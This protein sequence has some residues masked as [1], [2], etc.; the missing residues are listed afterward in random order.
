MVSFMRSRIPFLQ[1]KFLFFPS[2]SAVMD[3]DDPNILERV[4]R[5]LTSR[6]PEMTMVET[7]LSTLH[8]FRSHEHDVMPEFH[9]MVQVGKKNSE[10]ILNMNLYSY[11]GKKVAE[12]SFPLS[13]WESN[14]L[15]DQIN[16]GK[17]SMCRGVQDLKI[18]NLEK[19]LERVK[20]PVFDTIKR[21]FYIEFFNDETVVRSRLCQF[22]VCDSVPETSP[23]AQ[24]YPRCSQ[25]ESYSYKRSLSFFTFLRKFKDSAIQEFEENPEEIEIVNCEDCE[26]FK[27]VFN[28]IDENQIK[29]SKSLKAYKAMSGLGMFGISVQVPQ[30]G[31]H[32]QP[33]ED[34]DGFLD[35]IS[36]EVNP[37]HVNDKSSNVG[38]F[39]EPVNI[40]AE[41]SSNEGVGKVKV[42]IKEEDCEY[43]PEEPV[44]K[45]EISLANKKVKKKT[46]NKKS[47]KPKWYPKTYRKP[48]PICLHHYSAPSLIQKCIARHEEMLTLD[49]PVRCPMCFIEVGSKRDVTKHF[50]DF[51][52]DTGR[53]CCCECLLVIPNENNRLRRHFIKKHHS[54]GKPEICAQ[55]GKTLPTARELKIHMEDHV[56]NGAIC[57]E[58]GK[59]FTSRKLM[60]H[61]IGRHHRRRDLKCPYCEKLFV[62]RQQARKH[63]AMHTGMKPFKCPECKYCAY[64]TTNVHTHVSKTHG[65]KAD[66]ASI[67]I[68]EEECEKMNQM[69]KIDVDRM[70]QMRKELNN[71]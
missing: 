60:V 49:I 34:L 30:N 66:N 39:P 11:H 21:L 37:F 12:D 68:D 71:S 67:I 70:F 9:V 5:L 42:E 14:N 8:L 62:N 41:K 18:E 17:L 46:I 55:C 44:K 35:T 59:V 19:F 20:L 16:E 61:H 10:T 48:C 38:F 7:K 43:K 36:T 47:G 6:Y 26:P 3:E 25:C 56:N 2:Y 58:C 50:V 29:L 15:L 52:S 22:S 45:E 27:T 31:G 13:K 65:R 28:H 69:I 64:Q 24:D 54:A 32:L 57:H 1:N 51:H 33:D 4:K 23:N 53:T 40:K 63:M